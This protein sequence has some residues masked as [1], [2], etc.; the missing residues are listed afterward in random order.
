MSTVCECEQLE[1]HGIYRARHDSVINEARRMAKTG[2]YADS[3]QLEIAL[4]ETDLAE[5]L[6]VLGGDDVRADLDKLCRE[7]HAEP[8]QR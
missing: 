5:S 3:K 8:T 6:S 2:E 7:S 4:R 1:P